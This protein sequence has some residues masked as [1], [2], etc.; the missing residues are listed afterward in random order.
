M[1]RGIV[2]IASLLLLSG[3]TISYPVWQGDK[4]I[5]QMCEKSGTYDFT[6]NQMTREFAVHLVSEQEIRFACGFGRDGRVA[7]ACI[8]NGY[9]IYVSRGVICPIQVAHELNHGFGL[10]FVD[11]PLGDHGHG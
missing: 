8:V 11:R 1:V 7:A 9:D 2:N 4:G 6:H 3:C 5:S 10:H